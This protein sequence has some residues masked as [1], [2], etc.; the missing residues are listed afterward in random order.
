MINIAQPEKGR[1]IRRTA[2]LV[3]FI[4][5]AVIRAV[6]SAYAKSGLVYE[7]EL[8]NLE[9]A[10]NIWL[11]NSFLV[12]HAPLNSACIL[13]PLLISPFYA[14]SASI[15]RLCAISVFN[16]L[17]V[18]SA[19]IPA[20]FLAKRFCREPRHHIL[21]LA[22]LAISPNLGL[23][24]AFTAENLMIP[25]FLWGVW[26]LVKSFD[27]DPA[28][29]GYPLLLGI[30]SLLL[31]LTHQTGPAFPAA[32]FV[33]YLCSFS[34]SRDRNPDSFRN[35]I[36]FLGSSLLPFLLLRY[37]L[38]GSILSPG[39]PE[40]L[41]GFTAPENLLFF[42]AGTILLLLYYSASWSFWPVI[43]PLS[44]CG[45][46]PS[47]GKKLAS[48]SGC[49][50]LFTAMISGFSFCLSGETATLDIPARQ[51]LFSASFYPLFLLFLSGSDE[52]RPTGK[53]AAAGW[54]ISLLALIL[55][56]ANN[57]AAHGAMD[58]P[59]LHYLGLLGH[60]TSA[61]PWVRILF[62]AILVIPAVFLFI[63][64]RRWMI[65]FST[66]VII[67]SCAV[68]SVVFV[69]DMTRNESVSP[70]QQG[71]I[72]SLDRLLHSLETED[73]SP[74]QIL[75]IRDS[76]ESRNAEILEAWSDLD[77]YAVSSEDLLTAVSSSSEP[78][79]AALADLPSSGALRAEQLHYI[80]SFD[81]SVF[82][83]PDCHEEISP[84]NAPAVPF[85][86]YR[87]VDPQVIAAD[88]PRD[89]TPGETLLFSQADLSA[90]G[91][92]VSG[93]YGP[94]SSYS[95]SRGSES[96]LVLHPLVSR[97]ADLTMEL[98][99]AAT[100]GPQACRIHAGDV[101]VYDDVLPTDRNTLQV[102]I[103]AESFH[104]GRIIL[105]F[106]YPN[107]TTPGTGD[108]RILAVAF[109][110]IRIDTKAVPEYTPGEVLRFYGEDSN[111]KPYLVAGFSSPESGYTWA[112]DGESILQLKL[113]PDISGDL[114]VRWTWSALIGYQSC[115]IYAGTQ[116]V[117]FSDE[118]PPAGDYT[119]TVPADCVQDGVLE[120]TFR[121]P[122]A[123]PPG[124]GDPRLLSAAFRELVI[125][126][127]TPG[128]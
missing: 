36:I 66:A 32:V 50:L 93:F 40:T 105:R 112:T 28:A 99:W 4:L 59:T 118:L 75:L 124:N 122:Y 76:G 24:A 72:A 92:I 82:L 58:S 61:F 55:L 42:L 80:L 15:P 89:Y 23:S 56:F 7:D 37:F 49:F 111:A 85:R 127:Q 54:L 60:E 53:K 107:A 2:F 30:W 103:P 51:M 79:R 113:P 110:S 88:S 64:K 98:T 19:L 31:C 57:P 62:A 65:L 81:D 45:A 96:I 3:L 12:H 78:F 83:D 33:L 25:L 109:S 114:E 47:A 38:T 86:L 39:V 100:F 94:E 20:H 46:S 34:G 67:L 18:S 44:L 9:L 27:H 1:N 63:G 121:F 52:D 74:A 90:S 22:V 41:A 120:L 17:L 35:G 84:A 16:A 77:L 104:N 43:E 11:R 71:D 26:F 73:G 116:S 10:Q 97:P 108:P 119:F 125:V 29:S 5:S 21:A 101:L 48:F 106:E 126:P 95:W 87:S 123:V 8:I 13:Y 6:L 128:G 70:Q 115:E 91:Y 117:L 69:R 102:A 14:I 68:C